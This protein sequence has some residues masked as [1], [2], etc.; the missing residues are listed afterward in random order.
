MRLLADNTI[1]YTQRVMQDISNKIS[2]QQQNG[3]KIGSCAYILIN[4]IF[5]VLPKSKI[6]QVYLWHINFLFMAIHLRKL[7]GI[8]LQSNLKWDKISTT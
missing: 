7:T 2:K 4:A 3:N 1:I 6:Y 5:L 8:T